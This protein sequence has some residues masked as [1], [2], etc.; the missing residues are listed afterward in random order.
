MRRSAAWLSALTNN[1]VTAY[2]I[3]K[4]VTAPSGTQIPVAAPEGS[5]EQLLLGTSA[6]GTPY[7]GARSAWTAPAALGVRSRA[8]AALKGALGCT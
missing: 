2:R 1:R 4:T 8:E 6:F 7:A 3:G 5:T